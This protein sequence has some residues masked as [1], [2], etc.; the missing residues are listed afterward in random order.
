M[1]DAGRRELKDLEG[2]WKR[3]C[4]LGGSKGV[5]RDVVELLSGR[6]VEVVAL[7]RR[8]ESKK[9]LE[10]MEGGTHTPALWRTQYRLVQNA[11]DK[12]C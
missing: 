9:E 3:V 10:K 1:T 11:A 12:T 4:V 6:G 7:V 8:E 2:Q 5:G